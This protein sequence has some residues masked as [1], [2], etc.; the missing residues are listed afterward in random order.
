MFTSFVASI[1]GEIK[2]AVRASRRYVVHCS[3]KLSRSISRNVREEVRRPCQRSEPFPSPLFAARLVAIP[4]LIP[5]ESISSDMLMILCVIICYVSLLATL[6]SCSLLLYIFRR[7]GQSPVLPISS[8]EDGERP[9]LV[10]Y[11]FPFVS[12]LNKPHVCHS[13]HASSSPHQM[14]NG[15]SNWTRL[16]L[17]FLQGEGKES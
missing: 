14:A 12:F 13:G 10:A 3:Y 8:C 5:S 15:C 9:S 11:F 2:N 1:L 7:T 4:L 6:S 17:C 16:A